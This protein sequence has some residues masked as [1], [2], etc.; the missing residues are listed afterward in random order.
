MQKIATLIAEKV[1]AKCAAQGDL[2][3][4]VDEEVID[5]VTGTEAATFGGSLGGLIGGTEGGARAQR[6]WSENLERLRGRTPK[7][8]LRR[9]STGDL[10]ALT[11]SVRKGALRGG[12]GLGALGAGAGYGIHHLLSQDGESG[13]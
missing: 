7:G 6:R 2:D 4:G 11:R 10:G 12:L 5:P 8:A 13:E 9:V 3:T 1:L